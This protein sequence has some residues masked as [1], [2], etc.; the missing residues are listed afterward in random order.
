MLKVHNFDFLK[1]PLFHLFMFTNFYFG[2][3]VLTH[4]FQIHLGP[5]KVMRYNS[6]FDI[7]ISA[8]EK[9]IIEYWS[10]ATLQFPESE[11]VLMFTYRTISKVLLLQS[12]FTFSTTIYR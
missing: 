8:D 2:F 4:I 1:L 3:P 12:R 9:G 10:P 7:V 11:Y 6:V 5:V